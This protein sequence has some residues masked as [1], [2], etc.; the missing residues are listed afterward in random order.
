MKMHLESVGLEASCL[1]LSLSISGTAL[2]F[3]I[4]Y[5]I[6]IWLVWTTVQEEIYNIL[7]Q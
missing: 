2:F 7:M 1:S 4:I 3:A 6:I 5:L